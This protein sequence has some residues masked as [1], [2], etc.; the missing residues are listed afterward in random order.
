LPYNQNELIW[1]RP[2][3]PSIF[4]QIVYQVRLMNEEQ[5]KLL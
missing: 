5:Q 1:K 3:T 4:A 2:A